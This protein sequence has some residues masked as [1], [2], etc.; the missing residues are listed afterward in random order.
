MM[1]IKYKRSQA[2]LSLESVRP[3]LLLKR[4]EIKLSMLSNLRMKQY[5]KKLIQGISP[6]M[7][8]TLSTY[9]KG[10]LLPRRK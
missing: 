9:N 8:K 5:L 7:K 6:A 10:S 1:T 4:P 3:H 2:G